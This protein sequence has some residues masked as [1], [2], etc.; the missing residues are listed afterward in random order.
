MKRVVDAS[1]PAR[2]PARGLATDA[3]SMSAVA[4]SNSRARLR[5]ASSRADVAIEDEER[6]E[7]EPRAAPVAA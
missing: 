7:D 4:A 3:T 5:T 6:G 1:C 2:A